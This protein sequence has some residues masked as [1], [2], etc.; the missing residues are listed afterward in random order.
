MVVEAVAR[1]QSTLRAI[2]AVLVQDKAGLDK[3]SCTKVN[4]NSTI[5]VFLVIMIIRKYIDVN[6]D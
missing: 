5:I 6:V 4:T 1:G 3:D 2:D